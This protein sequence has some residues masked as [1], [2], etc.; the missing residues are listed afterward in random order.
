[1]LRL[2]NVDL[3][4]GAMLEDTNHYFI[5]GFLGPTFSNI[6]GK[7]FE[8]LKFNDRYFY[9]NPDAGFTRGKTFQ[10]QKH[11]CGACLK[12]VSDIFFC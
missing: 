7:Q 5:D 8:A 11:G 1:M 12:D 2:Y 10:L 4:A 9:L 3:F 6:I